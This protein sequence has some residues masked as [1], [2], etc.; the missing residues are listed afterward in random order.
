MLD[1]ETKKRI[2]NARNILVGKV[3]DPKA[4]VEQIT[5]ALI[6][7]FMDDM[8]KE[9]VDLGGKARF[10]V[11]DY[12][13]YSWTR[14][15]SSALSGFDRLNG[16]TEALSKM[17]LNPNLS[18]LFRDIFKGAFLPYSDPETLSLFLKEIHGFVYDHSE[19]LGDAFE[20]LL[21]VLGSQGDAGQF[22]TPR[23][24][25]D[26]ITQVVDPQK[27]ETI[28]DPA[29]GTAG[30]L[31]SAYKHI[32]NNNAKDK[33]GDKLSP[34]ER[35]KIMKHLA[36]YDISPDM[37]RLSLVNMY[38]H[39]FPEPKILEYDTLTS[40]ERWDEHFDVIL[41]NPPFMTP[42]GGI[43]P[44]KRFSVQA[45]RS[46]VLFVDYIAEHLNNNGRAGIVVP[47]G[48]VF[49]GDGAY[50]SLRKMFV[51][52][53]YLIAVIS[54]PAGVF[55]PYSGVKTSILILDKELAK[56]TKDILF[57]KI[58]NDGF[59]LTK[60]RNAIYKN[61]LPKALEILTDYRKGLKQL[62]NFVSEDNGL[63]ASFVL[64]SEIAESKDFNLTG[65]KYRKEE[66]LVKKKWPCEYIGKL[67]ET[68]VPPKKILK[69][70]FK[71]VGTF[72][73]IDQS[74]KEI[75]SGW[76]NDRK[77]LITLDK[78]LVLFGDHTCAVKFIDFAFCQ[79]AD[80]VKILKAKPPIDEKFLYFV[81]K[82]SSVIKPDGYKRHFSK[83]KL[84]KVPLPPL[85]VQN[86]IVEELDQYQK[87][88]DGAKQVIDNW[89]PTI[90]IDPEW[91]MVEIGDK[92]N[93]MTG[94]TPRSTAKEYY[95]GGSVK[96]LV[97]GD[98]HQKQIFDCPNRITQKG[99]ENSNAK[100]LPL[101]S[102]LIALNGQ[103]KTRGTVA[104]LRTEA[105][106]NQSLVAIFPKNNNE[107]SSEYLFLILGMMY[108][109]LRSLTGDKQRSGLNMPII[110]KVRVPLAP[111]D[112]QTR[113]VDKISEEEKIMASNKRLVEIYEQKIQDKIQS[114]F[115]QV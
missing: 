43:R 105:S 9:S 108:K 66:I 62:K 76:T 72:P 54:L 55:E 87:I 7:K 49:K 36:G 91:P 30:F 90:N 56:K 18:P 11:G 31:I 32:L 85:N 103:G 3:P 1:Q 46:E 74:A 84:S 27:N 86:Q 29:C 64:K 42:K 25:I 82:F 40:E 114:I 35:I 16:Y 113:L 70:Q 38:L 17:S 13:Q 61:D 115:E 53:H 57:V 28:L 47:E 23:H 60:Q 93:L 77:A 37:V 79:G 50:K 109:E 34:Q 52:E 12:K 112:V 110:R 107:L 111:I 95:D 83:L 71:E 4:Q 20:Y 39:Q 73:I 59:S 33:P 14:L 99:L 97:S 69:S 68:V 8:D 100:V 101:D 5:I 21:S 10:F 80:G 81:L 51:E 102:V 75:I 89:K 6:Y 22:R 26:F 88:I 63:V 92:C 44:H 94:G 65:E 15:M 45:K 98:I 96:W 2:D 104:M 58:Q 78:P 41:A 24:I 19:R 67:I 48:I 106:C